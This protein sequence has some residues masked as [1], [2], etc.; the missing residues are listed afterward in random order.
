MNK[1]MCQNLKEAT[2]GFGGQIFSNLHIDE[3]QLANHRD[4]LKLGKQ[5]EIATN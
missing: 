4:V 5:W 3:Q 1:G 2:N